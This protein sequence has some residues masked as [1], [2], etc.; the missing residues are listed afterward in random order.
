LSVIRPPVPCHAGLIISVSH[1]HL[2]I[3]KSLKRALDATSYGGIAGKD[4]AGTVEGLGPDV[5]E[6]ARKVGERVAGFIYSGGQ[7]LS[8]PCISL[9]VPIEHKNVHY[10]PAS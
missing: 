3:G 6:G 4:Y 2:F 10:S 8:F 1:H 7:F 5:P 9:V